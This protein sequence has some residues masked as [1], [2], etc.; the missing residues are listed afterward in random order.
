[1]A[2]YT[3]ADVKKLRELTG[4]GMMDCK[5]A[6]DE[7][8]G[9][10]DKAVEILRVKGQKGVAKRESRTAENGAVIA[11][12]AD[13]NTA[14][15]LVELKCETDFVAK[16]EKFL[17]VAE[18]IAA[19]V[20]A[21]SPADIDALLS[22]EIES[23]KTVQAYVDEANASLGEKIV[24][25]RFAQFS[26]AYVGS[27]LHRT[28]PD[29]PPQV[30]VLVELD[31]ANEEIAKDVAQ[32]IAAFAPAYLTR[33]DIPE[34]TVANERRIAEETAREEG[35]PEQALPKI[36]EGRVNGFFKENTL[37]DQPFAKDNKKSV[38]KVLEEAGVSLKRF[39]RFRVGA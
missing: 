15:V 36:I 18:A 37:L 24:L 34:E 20:E 29:L 32:H 12:I 21:T 27:Y 1:M 39:A 14:G 4:A 25:D 6:L 8:E 9:S 16:G 19:H 26:G 5:K 35:K 3:A 31:S 30:G 23:G 28:S 13:D 17:A 7:A 22:S 10:V 33:E 11:R 2:N 38:Q